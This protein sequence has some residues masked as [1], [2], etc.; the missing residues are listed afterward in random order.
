[1]VTS[2][3]H[4]PWP[5]P[6][7]AQQKLRPETPS[8]GRFEF[9]SPGSR[10]AGQ[11]G[12]PNPRILRVQLTWDCQTEL[13]LRLGCWD[14][15]ELCPNTF[16]IIKLLSDYYNQI[17]F[18]CARLK[19]HPLRKRRDH[20]G[21]ENCMKTQCNLWPWRPIV[22]VCCS[23]SFLFVVAK[24]RPLARSCAQNVGYKKR[25]RTSKSSNSFDVDH[26]RNRTC[27]CLT[28]FHGLQNF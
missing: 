2:C 8:C 1:M 7:P 6:P 18:W 25:Q 15:L 17:C 13:P 21:L 3:H 24:C 11:L 22:L 12:S 27:C 23:I 16:N 19:R 4:D 20:T 28:C 5:F 26:T 9:L 14:G 10:A